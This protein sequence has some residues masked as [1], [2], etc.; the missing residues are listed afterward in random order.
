MRV[1][2]KSLGCKINQF[3]AGVLRDRLVGRGATIVGDSEDADVFIIQTCTVTGKSDYHCRQAIRRAVKRKPGGGKV[4]V[5][6]CYAQTSADDIRKIEGVDLVVGNDGRDAVADMILGGTPSAAAGAEMS[7]QTV[8]GRS[9]AFLK[10]QEGCDCSCSYCIVPSARGKGR[11]AEFEDVLIK[12]RS[13]I[14]RGFHEIVLTGVHLGAYGRDDG[15][16]GRGLAELVE[17]LTGL[18][19]HGRLRLSSLEPMEL[20][21]RLLGVIAEGAAGGKVCRHLH[22]PLQSADD[23]VLESMGRGYKWADYLSVAKRI[24]RTIPGALIGADVI[25]GYPA[26]DYESFEETYS[27]I[28]SSPVNYLHVFSYSPRRGTRAFDMGDPVPGDVKKERSRRLRELAARKYRAFKEGFIGGALTVVAEVTEM[29]AS[30]Y[31]DNYIRVFLDGDGLASGRPVEVEVTSV[32]DD[33]VRVVR[34]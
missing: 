6:G 30:G 5:T 8:C 1:S 13:L 21:D 2:I 16:E 15:R 3:D 4:V 11:S 28:E 19:G 26:E 10:V 25:V 9:R 22:I 20:D 17:S 27:R 14:D 29:S 7:A 18:D 23:G 31:T 34:L 33:E 12:A 32:T 24:E